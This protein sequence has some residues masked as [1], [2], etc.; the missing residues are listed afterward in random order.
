MSIQ[1]QVEVIKTFYNVRGIVLL[2]AILV[3]GVVGELHSL[4]ILLIE[5]HS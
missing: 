5:V 1:L 2:I 3:A 4:S